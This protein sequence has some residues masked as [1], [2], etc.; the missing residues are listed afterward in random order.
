MDI[1]SWEGTILI[2]KVAS[3]EIVKAASQEKR[4][5]SLY[6]GFF[7]WGKGSSSLPALL[8]PRRERLRKRQAAGWVPC[9]WPIQ[10]RFKVW[11]SPHLPWAAWGLGRLGVDCLPLGRDG[12][13]LREGEAISLPEDPPVA[14]MAS[15][16]LVVLHSDLQ[17]F[18][19][20]FWF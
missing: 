15:L 3:Q 6:L 10:G 13:G 11:D 7:L 14:K 4:L 20:S 12:P 8:A 18:G 5:S 19:T 16:P 1:H 9:P 2:V 17:P